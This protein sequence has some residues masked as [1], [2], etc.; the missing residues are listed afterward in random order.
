MRCGDG[1]IARLPAGDAMSI[2]ESCA[3]TPAGEAPSSPGSTEYLPVAYETCAS[4]GILS[5]NEQVMQ[6]EMKMQ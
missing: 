6:K 5:I 3:P 1:G 2:A 4:R